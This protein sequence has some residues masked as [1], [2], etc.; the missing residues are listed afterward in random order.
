MIS[1][2][3]RGS[4]TGSAAQWSLMAVMRSMRSWPDSRLRAACGLT[5]ASLA[6]ATIASLTIVGRGFPVASASLCARRSVSGSVGSVVAMTRIIQRRT[7]E[8]RVLPGA[9]AQSPAGVGEEEIDPAGV[10]DQMAV[11]RARALLLDIAN[12]PLEVGEEAVDGAAEVRIS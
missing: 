12:Q 10:G 2:G 9:S 6:F 5:P 8:E 3:A 1:S 7:V 11:H 4:Q